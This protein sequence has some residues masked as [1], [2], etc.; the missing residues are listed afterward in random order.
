MVAAGHKKNEWWAACLTWLVYTVTPG[1]HNIIFWFDW[2]IELIRTDMFDYDVNKIT[3]YYYSLLSRGQYY[4]NR[5]YIFIS[6]CR[7]L[8]ARFVLYHPSV[9]VLPIKY[10]IYETTYMLHAT[11]VWK[12]RMK[13]DVRISQYYVSKTFEINCISRDFAR[14]Y[15]RFYRVNQPVPVWSDESEFHFF[16]LSQK[17]DYHK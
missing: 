16:S 12:N 8:F 2:N 17:L 1:T 15:K 3:L 9:N 10:I 5:C 6:R 4:T 14:Q 13:I 7:I 11:H